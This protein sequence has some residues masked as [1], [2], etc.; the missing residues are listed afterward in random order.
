VVEPG[1]QLAL[2]PETAPLRVADKPFVVFEVPGEPRAWGRPGATIK[3]GRGRPYIHW[4]IPAPEAAYRKAIGWAARSAMRGKKPTSEAVAVLAH[5]FIGIPPSWHWLTRQKARSGA[6]LPTGTPDADNLLKVC[7]DSV[8]GVI[9]NDDAQVVDA[10]CIKRF[11]DKPALR[12]EI[13]E[14]IQAPK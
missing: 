5:A 12:I 9:W 3:W 10:R 7:L 11:S 4:Y 8:K 1:V 6:L 13:R 14:F 2:L